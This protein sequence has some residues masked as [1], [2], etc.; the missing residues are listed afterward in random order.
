MK[1]V[2]ETV[3]TLLDEMTKLG[4]KCNDR[5]LLKKVATDLGP[6]LRKKDASIV[7]CGDPKELETVKNNFLITKHNLT[8]SPE[9][10]E[11]IKS[12]CERMGASNRHKYRAIFYYLLV[13]DLGLSGHY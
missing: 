10:D 5:A 11:A 7:S 1:T 6:A 12:V 13:E 2:D 4:L 8:D 9:L 3:T